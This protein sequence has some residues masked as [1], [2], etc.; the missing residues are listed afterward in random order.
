MN[1]LVGSYMRLE[2]IY[3]MYI[4]SAFPLR[5]ETLSQ[6]RDLL[7]SERGVLSQSPLLETVPVYPQSGL[8]LDKAAAELKAAGLDSAYGDLGELG[9]ALFPRTRQLYKH[10]WQALQETLINNRDIVVTTGTG[11]GKTETFL[12]PLFAQLAYES[13]TWS[14][15]STP[16]NN[17]RW[18]NGGRA[19]ISQWGHIERPTAMRALILYPLNALVEDQLRRLRRALDHETVRAWLDTARQGNRITFGRYTGL[20]PVPG[21]ENDRTLPKLRTDLR[22]MEQE[23]EEIVRANQNQ[24]N[25]DDLEEKRWYFPD[26][27]SGEMWSRWDMQETPPDILITNYSMLNIMMM[28]SIEGPIFEK[29]RQWL[30]SDTANTFHLIIDELHAYRGTPG[31]EV[32]YIIRLLLSRL[33]LSP[34]SQQLRI[35]TTTASLD[36]S[37]AGRTFL[38][39]FFGR[40][41]FAF[42][43]GDQIPPDDNARFRLSSYRRAFEQF[44]QTV[45]PDPVKPMRPIEIKPSIR[46]AMTNLAA[47]LGFEG[48][49]TLTDEQKLGE[50]LNRLNAGDALRSACKEKNGSVRAT[51]ITDLDPLLFPQKGATTSTTADNIVSS[52]FRGFLLA[53]GMSQRLGAGAVSP[54][55]VRGHLFFH[56]LQNLWACSNPRCDVPG[57]ADNSGSRPSVGALFPTH[58]LTCSCGARVL[59]LIV[60]E[61]CGE[62]FLGGYKREIEEGKYVVTADEPELEGVPDK[63]GSERNYSKY[64]IFWPSSW[65]SGPQT[66][67][68][69]VNNIT[70]RWKEA[71]LDSFS[72]LLTLVDKPRKTRLA[73]SEI[74][75]W[76]YRIVGSADTRL[77]RDLEP[78]M[79]TRC[80]CC[81]ADYA[82]RDNNPTP[83]RNHRTGFQKASQVLASGLLREMPEPPSTTAPSSRKLVIF[84]DSRQDAAKLAAGMQRDHYRDLVRMTLIQ[85]LKEYW[86]DLV[87]FLRF[88]A[89]RSDIPPILQAL[90]QQLYEQV[91]IAFTA[92]DA[93]P[94]RRFELRH[95]DLRAAARDW[96]DDVPPANPSERDEWINLLKDY[97]NR[98]SLD[99]LASTLVGRLLSLGV[100]P[101][102]V[103]AA[104]MTYEGVNGKQPWYK[105]Y[106]WPTNPDE[107]V[108]QTAQATQ[109][110]R[111]HIRDIER[112][113]PGELMYA[114]FPHIART[115]E[116]LGQGRITYRPPNDLLPT[117]LLLEA[118]DVVIRRLGTRRRHTH[119]HFTRPGND[120]ALPTL[121]IQ[122]LS[123]IGV[124]SEDVRQ[125]LLRSRVGEPSASKLV[126]NPHRLYLIPASPNAEGKVKGYRCPQCRSF[127]LHPASGTCPECLN[128]RLEETEIITDFDYYT[129]LS[130][131]SGRPFRM[132]CEE[133]T[134]QT[135]RKERPRRQRWFQDIFVDTEIRQV[136][137]VDLLSVTTTM[138]A[139]VDIG[140]LLAV[141]LANMPPRRFNYQQR[142]G[143]AGRRGAGV[144]LAVTF[145]RGRNHDDFYFQRPESITGDAPP[146][147]YVDMTSKEIFWR[148]LIKE[149]LRQAFEDTGLSEAIAQQ[150][151]AGPDSVHGEFGDAQQ[152]V[153]YEPT[154]SGWLNNPANVTQLESIVDTLS[155]QT[156][157]REVQNQQEYLD[158]RSQAIN[159]LRDYL[160]TEI[161]RIATDDATYTQ[162]A[163]SERLANAGRLPMFGF[164]TR[165]RVLYTQ[166]PYSGQPWPPE[167]GIVDRDLDIAITQF[168]PGSQT[169]KDKAVHTA[170]GV[171]DLFPTQNIVQVRPGFTPGLS[172]GNP[173]PIGVCNSCG[174][175]ARIQPVNEPFPG[176]IEPPKQT[177]EVCGRDTLRPIDAREPRGFFSDQVERDFEGQFEWLP[178]SS[179]PSMYFDVRDEMAEVANAQ[180]V[181]LYEHIVSINDNGGKGGFD[182]HPARVSG[183]RA[184]F[185]DG[186]YTVEPSYERN[187]RKPV[188]ADL[189]ISWRI[190]LLSKRKTNILLTSI[191]Q[192]PSGCYAD[193]ETIEGRAA[194][195]S[196]AF[197]LRTVACNYL[198]VDVQELQAG[199][200]TVRGG[201]RPAGE[202]ILCDQLENGAGYCSFLGKPEIFN[203]LLQYADLQNP[204][205]IAAQWMRDEHSLEC[206][207]SCNLCMRD[208]G[209]MN[210]HSLLDWRL[211]LD[212]AQLAAG[213]ADLDLTSKWGT[214]ENPWQRSLAQAIPS[215]L[216]KLGYGDQQQFGNLAGY[217]NN[218]VRIALITVHPLWQ[219]DNPQYPDHPE[220]QFARNEAKGQYPG[221][222]I[223][224]MNPF[225]VLRR[226]ADY[227]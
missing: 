178:R 70:R 167:S 172:E 153:N 223:I 47:Q 77:I 116:G 43:E 105:C 30:E 115:L 19:R 119:A 35:L 215:T 84:T 99:R 83:L 2:R 121:V 138:E 168:A 108:T 63:I 59:D 117:P 194:W 26:P 148:V 104:L 202:T 171:V 160:I 147:P 87:S 97:P 174:A 9:K 31:T 8:N 91:S 56:N 22:K 53:L 98:V 219:A 122:H 94:R 102:G 109:A 163:L 139:G 129:Y 198:D 85:T 205:S 39:E 114:L 127:Y 150:P 1:D 72:G 64:A 88:L 179:R 164:P 183:N 133:L 162:T 49:P 200:R 224:P 90:N 89:S 176:G 73:E 208:Y 93:F 110:E 188:A 123:E 212:M 113:V 124:P 142:V 27:D 12:L 60:C 226:P 61:V 57:R 66:P 193:P 158:F 96:W 50:A 216:S 130:E 45:Q 103:E 3:R 210:Y 192:W 161:T 5:D 20:T 71:A 132:N 38:K 145:C 10:Q 23:Y 218:A 135:D 34:D 48:D 18:W 13:A 191:A 169:V 131:E 76:V 170:C 185:G 146:P 155:V 107:L 140:S 220:Y 118:T 156:Q 144:S 92:A 14:R 86:G 227:V 69:R 36:K 126:L 204:N 211:A 44:A 143:R 37:D 79:P 159:W 134:G 221:Y 106:D 32:A 24:Q 78:A 46:E 177:C 190:A 209:N 125:Q 11:S 7:L 128:Q 213:R 203:E 154:I 175:V 68:W 217:T 25:A 75:G 182:F 189:N 100:N 95:N 29:T 199:F 141:M 67:E 101:G 222:R 80:P 55:P 40:D 21:R 196:F 58:R 15:N 186:A 112:N 51:K 225:R 207:T 6:E 111:D 165:V 41:N 17:R 42:I 180:V 28:R 173:N 52:A 187:E 157:W 184:N 137:G 74:A 151:K 152:W 181:P 33:G 214:F 16:Q 197:W 62:V 120:D 81:D 136:Q 195:Y 82:F 65:T 149:V 206:D 4:K 201:E 166:W 54:Q